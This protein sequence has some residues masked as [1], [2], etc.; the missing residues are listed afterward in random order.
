M[1]DAGT[2]VHP[3][4]I[5]IIQQARAPQPSTLTAVKTSTHVFEL[6]FFLSNG[7]FLFDVDTSSY[8]STCTR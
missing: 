3:S 5:Y 6:F 4:F 8:F 2:Q 7:Q 1:L